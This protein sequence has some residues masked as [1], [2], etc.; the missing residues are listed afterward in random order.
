MISALLIYFESSEGLL[1]RTTSFP[2]IRCNSLSRNLIVVPTTDLILDSPLA[3][4]GG[5][6]PQPADSQLCLRVALNGRL[7]LHLGSGQVTMIVF[8]IP[9]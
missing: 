3:D 6:G 4:V 8:C 2:A 7:G 9:I 1:A 5:V